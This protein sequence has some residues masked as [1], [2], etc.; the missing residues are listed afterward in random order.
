MSFTPPDIIICLI[1]G[2]FTFNGLRHGFIEEM[3]RIISLVGG[4]ILA[5][6]FH[7]LMIPYLK[8]YIETS[9]LQVT[10]AYMGIFILSVIIIT[11]IAKIFQK[12]IF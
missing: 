5:S 2:F 10:V 7:H 9:S 12:F 11:I 3:A 4:F 1:L 6:K 8:D